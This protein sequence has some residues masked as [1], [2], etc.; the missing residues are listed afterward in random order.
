MGFFC[1]CWLSVG[2]SNIIK[3]HGDVFRLNAVYLL[4]GR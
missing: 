3:A 2:K 4:L 1:G